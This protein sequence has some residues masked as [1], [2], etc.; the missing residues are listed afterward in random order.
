MI[1]VNAIIETNQENIN[2][3]KDRI[4]KL[5]ELSRVETGCIDYTW[6]VELG[7]PDILRATEK[8]NSIEDLALHFQTPHVA[9]FQEMVS[10][11]PPKITAYFYEAEEVDPPSND[12][13]LLDN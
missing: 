8:W 5:Q 12:L 7:D 13:S 3:W 4:I 1:V 6:S 2:K 9:S 11:S 10:E